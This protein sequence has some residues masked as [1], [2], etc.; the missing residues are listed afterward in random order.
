[1]F[2][3]YQKAEICYAYLDDVVQEGCSG[4]IP[5]GVGNSEFRLH[6]ELRGSKWFTR[7]WTLQELI[8]PRVLLMLNVDWVDIGYKRD[9]CYILHCIIGIDEAMLRGTAK[10]ESFSIAKR[11][12]WAADRQTTWPEDIAYSLMGIFNV[13]LP[14]IYGEGD[15]AFLRLQEEIIRNSDDHSIFAWERDTVSI[16][17]PSGILSHAPADFKFSA[18]IVP[19]KMSGL[20]FDVT[21]RGI[22]LQLNLSRG[23]AIILP[24]QDTSRNNWFVTVGVMRKSEESVASYLRQFVRVGPKLSH[25]QSYWSFSSGFRRGTGDVYVA[26]V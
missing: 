20:P 23:R 25:R 15:K 14:L 2:A 8:A 12:S 22:R 5:D 6:A 7:G 24:C 1:M 11:M 18:N 13:N 3:W 17:N 26:K 19:V 9:L 21:N 10:L 16:N 4:I